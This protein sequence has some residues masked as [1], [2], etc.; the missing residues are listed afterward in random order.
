M[1]DTHGIISSMFFAGGLQ[2][3]GACVLVN[4]EPTVPVTH[5][6]KPASNCCVSSGRS[7]FCPDAPMRD[8][9]KKGMNV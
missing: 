9:L 4:G 1:P 2:V 3:P 8:L 7:L 6:T 5:D